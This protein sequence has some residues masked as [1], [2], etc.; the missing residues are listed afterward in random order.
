MKR[1]LLGI[2][3]VL[4]LLASAGVA[5]AALPPGGTFTDDDGNTFEGAIEAIAAE[6]I[7]KGCNP[8]TNDLYCP[9]EPVTRGQMSAFLHRALP[10][11]PILFPEA[12]IFSDVW[13][14]AVDTGTPPSFFKDIEWLAQTGVTRGCNPPA[15][16]NFCPDDPV[17]RAQMAAFLV[18]ALGY[19]DDGGGDLFVDDDDSIFEAEI[20]KLATARVTLGCNPPTNDRFCPDESVTRGQMAAFLARAL[21]LSPIIPPPRPTTTTT[22]PTTTVPSNP[23]DNVNCDD[24]STWRAAQNYF[25]RYYP[26][27]GDVARLDQDNDGIACETLPGAP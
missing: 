20:D 10:G 24:F 13:D 22:G 23:G 3:L 6:G 18:R 2:T 7:T 8:P 1:R 4:G 21:G 5:Y 11:L 25:D 16:T 17:T 19:A 26:Y 27:Y 15:N 12:G 9:D 14:P